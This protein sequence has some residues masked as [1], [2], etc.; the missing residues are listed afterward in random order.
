M[1]STVNF[2][3]I[4]GWSAEPPDLLFAHAQMRDSKL[5]AVGLV[6]NYRERGLPSGHLLLSSDPSPCPLQKPRTLLA[7]GHWLF[8]SPLASVDPG[9]LKPASFHQGLAQC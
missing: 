4:A 8:F 1:L 3:S 7:L 9:F 2:I 6:V 5:S